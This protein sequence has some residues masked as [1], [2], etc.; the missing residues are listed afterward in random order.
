MFSVQGQ[1][2]H[3][4]CLTSL[5]HNYSAL[6]PEYQSG[7]RQCLNEWAGL[8][9]HGSSFTERN[10]RVDLAHGLQFANS[11]SRIKQDTKF[12]SHQN[13]WWK[14]FLLLLHKSHF[15]D[16]YCEQFPTHSS[17][18]FSCIY[19]SMYMCLSIYAQTCMSIL[20]TIVHLDSLYTEF[21]T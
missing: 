14:K 6:P 10:R 5:R 20:S 21:I 4:L 9:S 17:R 19:T 7:H 3:I 2:A 11:C 8:G 15:K 16:S 18:K 13:T 1:I 12:S